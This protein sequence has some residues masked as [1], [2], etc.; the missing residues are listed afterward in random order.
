MSNNF[1]IISP[2]IDVNDDVGNGTDVNAVN[3]GTPTIKTFDD[4][5]DDQ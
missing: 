1:D 2:L 5:D 4:V 3:N